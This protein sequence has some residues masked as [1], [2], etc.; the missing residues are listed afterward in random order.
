MTIVQ[1][2]KVYANPAECSNG[3][4]PELKA[5]KMEIELDTVNNQIDN[6]IYLLMCAEE[7]RTSDSFTEQLCAPARYHRAL[8][9]LTKYVGN[10][11]EA[12]NPTKEN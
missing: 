1:H 9:K 5:I 6:I 8:E 2:D 3:N 10:Y 12:S 11:S 7:K 4:L